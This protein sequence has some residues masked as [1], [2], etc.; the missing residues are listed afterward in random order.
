[1]TYEGNNRYQFQPWYIKLYRRVRYQPCM[2]MAFA[3]MLA[4]WAWHGFKT[5][6]DETRRSTLGLMW[7]ISRATWT[8]AAGW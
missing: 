5:E 4:V 2:L 6:H 7:S 3:C 1:M 8:I